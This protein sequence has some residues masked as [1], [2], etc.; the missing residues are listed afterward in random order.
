[1]SAKGQCTFE[2]TFGKRKCE[3]YIRCCRKAGHEGAHRAKWHLAGMVYWYW[4][5]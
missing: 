3:E 5:P 1:V 2:A 4:G